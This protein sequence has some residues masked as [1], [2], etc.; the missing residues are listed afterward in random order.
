[1]DK[2]EKS[3]GQMLKQAN[4]LKRAERLDEAIALYHQVIEI[5]PHFAWAYHGLGNALVKEE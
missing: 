1:M 5:N 3:V 4:H 2:Q